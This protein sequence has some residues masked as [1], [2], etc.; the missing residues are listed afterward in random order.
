MC[1]SLSGY[2]G[3]V[4][5]DR[6]VTRELAEAMEGT[7][8]EAIIA[9]GYEDEALPILRQRK[10]LEILAVP[11]HAI[12]GGRPMWGQ[13]RGPRKA[14]SAFDYQRLAGGLL[15]EERDG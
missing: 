15:V 14:G 10:N 9:P 3:I 6:I 7:F 8:Y 11:G 13:A 12:V 1:H 2:G 5:A 4:G